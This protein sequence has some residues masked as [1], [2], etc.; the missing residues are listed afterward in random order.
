LDNHYDAIVVAASA[1]TCSWW[2]NTETQAGKIAVNC[3]QQIPRFR[4]IEN[5]FT[6]EKHPITKLKLLGAKSKIDSHGGCMSDSTE[7]VEHPKS[8]LRGDEHI[9]RTPSKVRTQ[10]RA[11]AHRQTLNDIMNYDSWK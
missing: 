6:P 9:A 5:T 2:P 7:N 4:A 10:A 3:N 11:Q 8:I 1:E